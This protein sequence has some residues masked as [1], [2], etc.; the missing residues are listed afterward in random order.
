MRDPSSILIAFVLPLILLFL[1]GYGVSLDAYAHAHRRG[2]WRRRRRP[3][4]S[5]AAAFRASRYFEA[6]VGRSTAVRAGAVLRPGHR[7][8][9]IIPAT[10]VR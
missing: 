9:V 2:E 7:G 8:V 4:A 3:R 1:F 5:F 6:R 10:F